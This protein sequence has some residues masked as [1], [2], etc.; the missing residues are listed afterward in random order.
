M[1]QRPT[2]AADRVGAV[3]DHLVGA[4]SRPTFVIIFGPSAV[5]KMT[6]GQELCALTGFKLLVNHMVADLVTEFVPF[7]VPAYQRATRAMYL[8]LLD[9][10]AEQGTDVV[11]TFAIVFNS[12]KGRELI[13]EL[14][15]PFLTRG[16]QVYFAELAAPLAVRIERNATENR[17][18]HKKVDWA[19]PE[20]LAEMERWGQW[21][22][23]GDAPYPD[24]HLVIDNTDV[25]PDAAARMIVER[26]GLPVID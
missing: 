21:N 10:A 25:A 5:G 24:R 3:G 17:R 26:F 6:V 4:V 16:G 9:A 15:A 7:G 14:S 12:P 20:R 22:T 23:Q 18:R 1:A 11:L 8:E 13:D 2:G 19:T